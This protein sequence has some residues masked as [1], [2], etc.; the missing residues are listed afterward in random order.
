MTKL[1]VEH[2]EGFR[3]VDFANVEGSRWVYHA[4]Q[5]SNQIQ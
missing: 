3:L 5:F 1:I 2:L 4:I